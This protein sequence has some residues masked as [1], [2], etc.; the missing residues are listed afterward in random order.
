MKNNYH[1]HK[2]LPVIIF[3]IAI[4]FSSMNSVHAQGKSNAN[5]LD[6]KTKAFLVIC[7]YGTTGGALLGLASMAFGQDSKAIAQGASLGLY[8]G[9]LFGAYVIYTHNQELNQTD[10]PYEENAPYDEPYV[11]FQDSSAFNLTPQLKNYWHGS[12]LEK[13]QMLEVKSKNFPVVSWTW[14]F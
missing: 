8:A 5:F 1:I 10:E 3:F 13:I 11:P 4:M 7:G 14:N 2:L 6:P 9:I 12:S